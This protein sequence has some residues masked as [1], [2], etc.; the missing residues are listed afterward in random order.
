MRNA[1][2][3]ARMQAYL[4]TCRETIARHGWMIQGVFPTEE[5]PGVEFSYTVGLTAA[6]LPELVISGLPMNLAGTLLNDAARLSLATAVEP[7]DTITT[8][9]SVAFN[10]IAAPKAEIG[11][12]RRLC[13]EHAKALQLIWPDDRGHYPGEAGWSLSNGQEIFADQGD[14]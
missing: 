12:A 8:I 11:L 6:G 2:R 10:V 3:D 9:A 13:G 5:S 1:E 7:G 4:L 14:R